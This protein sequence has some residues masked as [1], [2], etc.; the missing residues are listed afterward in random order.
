MAYN[1][2]VLKLGQFK[3]PQMLSF[4]MSTKKR[5]FYA[6]IGEKFAFVQEPYFDTTLD[7]ALGFIVGDMNHPKSIKEVPK[8]KTKVKIINFWA[9]PC[10]LR[11]LCS[12]NIINKLES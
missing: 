2:H 11:V 6:E 5:S 7:E 9:C 4:H 3:N 8:L 1:S 12:Q 10:R